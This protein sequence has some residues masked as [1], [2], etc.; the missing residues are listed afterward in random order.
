MPLYECHLHSSWTTPMSGDVPSASH[1][2]PA[3]PPQKT[4][5]SSHAIPQSSPCFAHMYPLPQMPFSYKAFTHF[6]N[7]NLNILLRSL[8]NLFSQSYSQLLPTPKEFSCFHL[9]TSPSCNA[10]AENLP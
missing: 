4:L 6:L 7:P 2:F 1:S 8:S 9:C 3:T 5:Y 10:W